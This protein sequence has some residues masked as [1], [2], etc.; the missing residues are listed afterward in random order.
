[1]RRVIGRLALIGL[2]LALTGCGGSSFPLALVISASPGTISGGGTYTF[3]ATTTNSTTQSGVIWTLAL[4][5]PSS[6]TDSTT[7]CSSPCGTWVNAGTA[8]TSQTTSGSTTYYNTV[9]SIT[10]TAPLTP[11]TPNA[12]VLTAAAP[13]NAAVTADIIF[14]VGAPAVVVRLANTFTTIAPGAAPVT[15]NATVQFDSTNKGVNW[16][17]AAGGSPCS[18]ACG[19]LSPAAAPSFSAVYTPPTIL[20]TAPNN[21]PT[22]TATSVASST[23]T[24]FDSFLIQTPP[25]PISVQITNPFTTVAAGSPG[26]TVN[27]QVTNDQQGQG[28]TWSISPSSNTG[29]LSANEA[30]SV[31]YTTPNTAPQPPYNTPTITATSVA[32]PTKS[33][34][35]TFTIES[36][37][38]AKSACDSA[39]QFAFYLHGWDSAGKP[40]LILGSMTLDDGKVMVN[41]VDVNENL[42]LTSGGGIT[43]SCAPS[44]ALQ[45]GDNSVGAITLDAPLPGSGGRT[46][47]NILL[48]PDGSS[49]VL[50]DLFSFGKGGFTAT[51]LRQDPGSFANFGGDFAFHLKDNSS[52]A[53]GRFTLGFNGATGA[54]TKGLM[55]AS[56]VVIGP[57]IMTGAIAGNATPP[58]SNGRGTMNLSFAGQGTCTFVYYAV[59]PNRFVL[60]EMSPD[61]AV[62]ASAS[63][64]FKPV[65][66]FG[67]G[68]S[69]SPGSFTSASV[70]GVRSVMLRAAADAGSRFSPQT[71]YGTFSILGYSA[72]DTAS[73]ITLKFNGTIYSNALR[74]QAT[75][76]SETRAKI[77]TFDPATGRATLSFDGGAAKG[78]V[79]SAV[80]YLAAP[81][82]G[83]FLE[84][85]V[86]AANHAL[87]GSL[88]KPSYPKFPQP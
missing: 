88:S 22:I 30:L 72:S 86:G 85:T 28:V 75:T 49:G 62:P 74:V 42:Q 26:V 45:T 87:S 52:A 56:V 1:M 73:A 18:P 37:S 71:L 82:E 15:L 39:G 6:T 63:L 66:A 19:T 58:D 60:A 57:V 17:L 77:V 25:L 65:F 55:D 47:F 36:S 23:A 27:A 21:S 41:A 34:S 7:P 53:A 51:L 80:M 43:G 76:L 46:T 29:S 4:N 40:L 54:I 5:T 81:A 10:Y 2:F 16:T 32:D 84:T 50:G 3:S 64:A 38:P 31:L 68:D 8:I 44:H 20:P 12:I 24:A 13:S 69:Q 70:N 61:A 14:E 83:T 79:D 67:A 35:F 33:A 48:H 11:P 9:T 78:F 59:S